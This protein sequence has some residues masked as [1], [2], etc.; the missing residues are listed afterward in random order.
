MILLTDSKFQKLI[1]IFNHQEFSILELANIIKDLIN[2][3][4]KFYFK[5]LPQEDPKQRKTPI[6]LAKE[7][8][9]WEPKVE[10]REGL[11]KSIKWF[12]SNL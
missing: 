5:D 1:N 12:K 6:Q 11:I 4:L 9:N 2:P 3:K 10:L 8:L 7:F